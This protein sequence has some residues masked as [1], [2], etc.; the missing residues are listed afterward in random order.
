[1]RGRYFLYA[2][3]FIIFI[4]LLEYPPRTPVVTSGAS[5]ANTGWDGTSSLM[6]MLKSR[7]YRVYA[8]TDWCS[9]AD[10]LGSLN[11][12][13]I[14]VFISPE[15][16][17]S[18]G[19]VRCVSKVLSWSMS[20]Y[21]SA[22]LLVADEGPYTDPIL[23]A[24]NVSVFIY[25]G[26]TL[27]SVK[28]DPYP[29]ALL[30][31]PGGPG[32]GTYR[33]Y[34]DYAAKLSVSDG[35]VVAGRTLRGDLVAAYEVR[36]GFKAYVISDGSIF[37]NEVLGLSSAQYNYSGFASALFAWLGSPDRYVVLMES[38]KYT[39]PVDELP[40]LITRALESVGAG[41]LSAIVTLLHPMIWFPLLHTLI[42]M[43][44]NELRAL[45]ATSMFVR[46]A[47]LALGTLATIFLMRMAVSFGKAETDK[48]LPQVSEVRVIV[49]TPVRKGIIGKKL[50]LGKEDFV[51][52]YELVDSVLK[53]TIGKGL[54][55]PE[56][57]RVLSSISGIDTRKAEKY[58]RDMN[59]LYTKATR[60]GLRPL[61]LSWNRKVKSLIRESDEILSKL[62]A[63]LTK[64]EG[65]E[66]VLRKV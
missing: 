35:A 48:A 13:V 28:G 64:G 26:V 59:A 18:S 63:A 14:A 6:S 17:Y 50:K 34:L 10:S 20:K 36:G 12:P 66:K 5:P 61:I 38:G 41:S 45:L 16:P 7:G 8:V 25:Y 53:K 40:N 32:A 49:D 37:I 11:S 23:K 60:G 21:G 19:E 42:L 57:V 47:S 56:I 58:V 43:A 62:G 51:A 9:V 44:D 4:A 29:L 52:L 65:V 2:V 46:L 27:K 55:E 54:K 33:L 15:E 39:P 3:I 22:S 31:V 24:L 1:M 30:K